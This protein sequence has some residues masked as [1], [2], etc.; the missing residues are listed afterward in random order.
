MQLKINLI[1]LK[2]FTHCE[3]PSACLQI[4]LRLNTRMLR[5]YVCKVFAF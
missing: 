5:C 4:M 2:G 1:F 3:G